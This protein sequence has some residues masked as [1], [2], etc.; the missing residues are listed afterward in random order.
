MDVAIRVVFSLGFSHIFRFTRDISSRNINKN[1]AIGSLLTFLQQLE[2]N[3]LFQPQYSY[4]M[5]IFSIH[6][7]SVVWFLTCCHSKRKLYLFLKF[8]QFF[9]LMDSILIRQCLVIIQMFSLYISV[10]TDLHLFDILNASLVF[11]VHSFHYFTLSYP[12]R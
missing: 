11:V 4:S 2:C 5:K 7:T 6:S 8:I 10:L 9:S 1:N 3:L 12:L